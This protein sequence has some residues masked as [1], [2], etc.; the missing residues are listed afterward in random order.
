MSTPQEQIDRIINEHFM[1]EATDNVDG[2]LGSLTPDAEH[3]VI[4]SPFGAIRGRDRIRPFYE[5]LFGDLKGEGV[6]PIR[7]LYG[8]DFV[9]DETMWHGRIEDGRVFLCDGRSGPVSF[10]LLHIFE[11]KEGKIARENVWVDLAAIQRQLGAVPAAAGAG[12]V[13]RVAEPG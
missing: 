7:R 10:R 8:N 6:T 4:P 12:P 2:V 3:E 13:T 5:M 11:L 1:F 9:V